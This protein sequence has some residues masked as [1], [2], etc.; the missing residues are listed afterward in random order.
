M[1][2]LIAGKLF[3]NTGQMCVRSMAPPSSAVFINGTA[4]SSSPDY[5]TSNLAA[6]YLFNTG[7][8]VTGSGVSLWADQSGNGRNLTQGTDSA[9]PAKQT[10][11]SILFDGTDDKL[12]TSALSISQP[13]TH[14]IWFKQVT[15]TAGDNI[16]NGLSTAMLLTQAGTTPALRINAGLAV[17]D[18]TNLVLDTYGVVTVVFNG[19]SS[20]LQVN[21]GTA[22]TGNAGSNSFDGFS[23]GGVT[24]YANIQVKTVLIYSAAHDATQRAA[25]YSYFANGPT[26]TVYVE[27]LASAAVP[28]GSV[29]IN[30]IAH[31]QNG[32]MYVT[33]DAPSSPMY[34]NGFA[35]RQDGALHVSTSTAAGDIHIG[36][37]AVS[38]DGILRIFYV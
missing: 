7:I 21:N 33:T 10:D 6:A 3:S 11:G 26:G 19:A 30:G 25:N 23:L 22:S 16:F 20:L 36:G 1:T 14:Y 15:W 28:A 13:L 27:D 18:N 2:V 38:Q 9:R 32:R 34:L 8:T 4:A 24:A 29:F 31:N 35:V 37:A 17:G 12:I 5:S